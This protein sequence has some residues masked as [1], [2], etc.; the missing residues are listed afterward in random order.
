MPLL[1]NNLKENAFCIDSS[2]DF[3]L[4]KQNQEHIFGKPTAND[5]ITERD[6]L[7]ESLRKGKAKRAAEIERMQFQKETFETIREEEDKVFDEIEPTKINL[8]TTK[9]FLA[10]KRNDI[11]IEKVRII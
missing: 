3:S 10:E 4:E 5:E 2:S 11:N 8:A 6:R 7:L 1:F 9:I